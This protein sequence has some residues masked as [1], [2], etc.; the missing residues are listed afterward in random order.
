MSV[1]E[2]KNDEFLIQQLEKNKMF[3]NFYNNVIPVHSHCQDFLDNFYSWVGLFEMYV[4][5]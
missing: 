5:E 2:R 1:V 4:D 3:M